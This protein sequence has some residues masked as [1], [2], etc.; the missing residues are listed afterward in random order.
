MLALRARHSRVVGVASEDVPKERVSAALAARVS[1]HE[2]QVVSERASD[3]RSTTFAHLVEDANGTP[4]RDPAEKPEEEE[5]YQP[6]AV[7]EDDAIVPESEE[8]LKVLEEPQD[9]APPPAAEAEEEQEEPAEE[10]VEVQAEAA[11]A[12]EEEKTPQ[13]Q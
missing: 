5:E 3:L 9:T 11:P 7:E 1:A 6:D 10:E 13:Y 2:E 4:E 12:A 8:P